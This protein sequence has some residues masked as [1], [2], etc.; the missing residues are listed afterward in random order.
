[1]TRRHTLIVSALLIAVGLI[2]GSV[3]TF[4]LAD[5]AKEKD[6]K[7]T[8]AAPGKP[9]MKLPPGWTEAD[10]QACMAAAT[11]GKMHEFL[12][13][14]AGTWIGKN[15]MWMAPDTEPMTAESTTVITPIMDGRYTKVEVKG[16]MPGMGPFE[17]F[18]IYGFDNVTQKFA[19]TWIDNH[20]TG[21]AQGTGA[22][23]PDGKTLTLNYTYNCPIT[24]K[25]T[26]VREIH[27][28]TGENTKSLE[29]WGTEPKSGKEF[30]M[31][32]IELTKKS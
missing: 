8:A 19:C 7:S 26:T 21:I 6:S 13:K 4:A 32:R 29:M 17:G 15:T 2:A 28:R 31:M 22:L 25:P 27:T 20:S 14:D 10:M 30:K 23:S 9:E 11:P 1:M 3:A 5:V 18:G 12:A 16:E 24:K